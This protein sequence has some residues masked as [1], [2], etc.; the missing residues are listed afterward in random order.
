[1]SLL[2]WIIIFSLLGSVGAI[3]GAALLLLFPERIRKTIVPC[4]VSYATGTLL[5]AAF[6]GMLPEALEHTAAINVLS[7]V[8]A[9]MILFFLLEK[10]VIWRHCHD[11]E[12]EVHS[13][14]GPLI[15]L[16]DAFHNFVDG[17]VIATAFLV[18]IPLTHREG[19]PP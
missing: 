10:L 8:L 14:A 13:T 15:L 7:V 5:G 1:M 4:L 6:L 9:G 3:G 2:F 11:G 12:C 18:S 16:G 17:V 19:F